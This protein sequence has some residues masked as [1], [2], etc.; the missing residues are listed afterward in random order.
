MKLALE[1][2]GYHEV[3][4]FFNSFSNVRDHNI[5]VPL[6]KAKYSGQEVNWR[7]QF[8][9]IFGHCAAVSDTP[10]IFSAKELVEAH[11]EAKVILVEREIEVWLKS[12]DT[13]AKGFFYPGYA[14]FATLDPKF[15]GRIH[16][17]LRFG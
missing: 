16:P 2:L 7:A 5:W 9:K 12:F 13:I 11:P 1:A 15:T 8:D 3:Y 17:R 6:L 10:A 14:L 4:H